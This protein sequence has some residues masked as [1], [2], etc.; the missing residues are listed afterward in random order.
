MIDTFSMTVTPVG[1][2]ICQMTG[3]R[4]ACCRVETQGP[5]PVPPKIIDK[6]RL[7]E[8]YDKALGTAELFAPEPLFEASGDS[9]KSLHKG[10]RSEGVTVTQS[11]SVSESSGHTAGVTTDRK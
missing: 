8:F 7:T 10:P 5:H 3:R 2:D 11:K 1:I 6:R 9:G 4:A